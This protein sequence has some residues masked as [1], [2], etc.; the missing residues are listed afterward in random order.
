MTSETAPPAPRGAYAERLRRLHDVY[1]VGTAAWTLCLFM[2]L[3]G[4]DADVRQVVVLLGLMTAFAVSWL[5][6]T[7][8]LSTGGDTDEQLDEG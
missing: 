4:H 6:C 3:L 5:W 8:R 2:S 7:W 1:A